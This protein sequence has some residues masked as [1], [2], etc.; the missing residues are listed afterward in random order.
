M[1]F[2]YN[3]KKLELLDGDI[4]GIYYNI[5]R[6][7]NTGNIREAYIKPTEIKTPVGKFDID[8]IYLYE[9][10]K[11]LGVRFKMTE[12]INTP[13]GRLEFKEIFFYESGKIHFGR[14]VKRQ[15][16][17]IQGQKKE[18]TSF[19]VYLYETGELKKCCIYNPIEVVTK[20]GKLKIYGDVGFYKNGKIKFGQSYGNFVKGIKIEELVKLNFDE[21]GNLILKFKKQKNKRRIK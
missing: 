18:V 11:L 12:F 14:F 16:I 17:K 5:E 19:P 3:G 4:D 2:I 7:K 21:D 6:Y 9:N 10:G 15:T 13:V 20:I 8:R 1:E